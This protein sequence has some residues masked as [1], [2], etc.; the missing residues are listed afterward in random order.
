M[1]VNRAIASLK[2]MFNVIGGLSVRIF[3]KKQTGEVNSLLRRPIVVWPRAPP[4]AFMDQKTNALRQ[5]AVAVGR[6]SFDVGK[7]LKTPTLSAIARS[8]RRV[9]I[10]VDR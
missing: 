7:V 9:N 1:V 8:A 6:T 10:E 4:S 2:M 3:A 5:W